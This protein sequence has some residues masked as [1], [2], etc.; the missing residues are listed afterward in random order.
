[1]ASNRYIFSSLD[2]IVNSKIKLGDDHIVDALGKGTIII[3]TKKNEIKDIPN[4]YFVQGL[5]HNLLSVG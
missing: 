3:I 2:S 4:V 5:K 1:M